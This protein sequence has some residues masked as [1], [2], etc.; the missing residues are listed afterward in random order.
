MTSEERLAAAADAFNNI[1]LPATEQN[2]V[3]LQSLLAIG[4]LLLEINNRQAQAGS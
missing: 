2:Y 4:Q 3:C 1:N